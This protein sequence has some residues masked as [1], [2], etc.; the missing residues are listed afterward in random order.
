MKRVHEIWY[1]IE[2]QDIAGEWHRDGVR[3][4]RKK[5][6]E[7]IAEYVAQT[8]T[9]ARVIRVTPLDMCMPPDEP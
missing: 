1:E 3:Y 5:K 2:Q 6:A 8:G 9:P 4:E 7:Y